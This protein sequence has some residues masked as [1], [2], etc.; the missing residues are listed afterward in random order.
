MN[1]SLNKGLVSIKLVPGNT[2]RLDRIRKA[3]LNDGFTPKGAD[4]VALGRLVSEGGKLRFVVEGTNETFPVAPT[5]HQSWEK[6]IGR[7]VTAKGLLAAPVKG[8]E[9]GALQITSVSASPPT[10]Q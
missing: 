2:V 4:V 3:I 6:Y 8:R 10:K 5:Q 7:E 9:G 1:V